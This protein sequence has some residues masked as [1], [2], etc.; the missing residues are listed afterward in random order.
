MPELPEVET[1]AR[2]VDDRLRGDRIETTWFS[3]KREPFKSSPQLMAKELPGRRIDRVHRV[4]KHI[5]FDLADLQWIVHLGMTGRLL[6]ADP[7]TPVPAHTHG[8]LHLASGRELRFVDPRRFGRMELR[9]PAASPAPA[10]S[11][12]TFR[13]TSSPRSFGPAAPPSKPPC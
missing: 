3:E 6:V 7:Q 9:S 4:G 2:G 8:I 13:R 10:G 11:R 1:I 5:V 12:S